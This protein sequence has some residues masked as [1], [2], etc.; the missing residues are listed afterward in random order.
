MQFF[1]THI[2]LNDFEDKVKEIIEKALSCGIDKMINMSAKPEDW[3]TVIKLSKKYPENIVPALGIHP[4]YAGQ[5]N[6]EDFNILE[7]LL[8]ENKKAIIG[9]CGLDGLK[10]DFEKQTEVFLRQTGLAKKYNRPLIIHNVKAIDWFQNNW[11]ELP[12]RFVFH[13]YNGKI[14][15]LK[16][17]LDHGG[18]VGFN[19]SVFRSSRAD[20]VIKYMPANRILLETDAPYQGFVRGEENRPEALVE[21]F[22]KLAWIRAENKQKLAS[23]IYQN[24]LNFIQQ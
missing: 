12:H 7:N 20:E 19:A 24:S 6:K 1:D 21:I 3:Q 15:F 18:Y 11:H 9:E 4:W 10:P 13:S 5:I 2:H 16:Q 14:D 8:K 22:E 23:K 17:I